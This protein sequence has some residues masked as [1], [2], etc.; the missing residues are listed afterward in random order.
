M[1]FGIIVRK[2]TDPYPFNED[3]EAWLKEL[4]TTERQKGRG[5]LEK[6]NTFC[7]LGIACHLFGAIR[8]EPAI[9]GG[10]RFKITEEG[11]LDSTHLPMPLAY[12]L[13]LRNTGGQFACTIRINGFEYCALTAMNDSIDL[14]T[15]SPNFGRHRFTFKDIAAYIRHDPWNV[16]I[17]EEEASRCYDCLP[18]P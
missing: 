3:Q 18:L 12:R 8:V 14:V 13:K 11:Q 2:N 10:Y 5:W 16:F 6:D 17:S 9:Y 15:G 1:D 4:E 7:C